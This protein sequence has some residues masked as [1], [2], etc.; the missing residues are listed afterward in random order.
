M[1]N[2]DAFNAS[3]ME[4]NGNELE[5]NSNDTE[6]SSNGQDIKEWTEEQTQFLQDQVLLALS[7]C[8]KAS[9]ENKSKTNIL[10]LSS[11]GLDLEKEHKQTELA[12]ELLA[13]CG[14]NGISANLEFSH[15]NT[16]DKFV[17]FFNLTLSWDKSKAIWGLPS[18]V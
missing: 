2:H 13:R 18:A 4:S 8:Q 12:Q 15:G 7:A 17:A 16:F 5:S 6:S 1:D 10:V 3:D 11:P 9:E 14:H